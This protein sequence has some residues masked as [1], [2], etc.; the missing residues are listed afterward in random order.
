MGVLGLGVGGVMQPLVLATQNAVPP[1][2]IGVATA[3]STFFRQMGG[4]LGAAVFLSV[5][6]STVTGKIATAFQ[7][8]AQTPQFQAAVRDP[9][10]QANPANRVVLDAVKGA[11]PVGGSLDDSSFIGKLTA[12]LAHPFK[13]GFAD[14]MHTGFTMGAGVLVIGF[15]VLLFLPEVPLRTQS[16]NAARAAEEEAE[17]EAEAAAEAATG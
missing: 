7:A 3:S 10:V 4:T 5:L 8:A 12:V 13:V 16:G 9:A 6:F 2:D 15:V 17:A 14:A 1:Q 11:S